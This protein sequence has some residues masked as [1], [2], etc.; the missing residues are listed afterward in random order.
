MW[1][2]T[3]AC[4]SLARQKVFFCQLGAAGQHLAWKLPGTTI[5]SGIVGRGAAHRQRAAAET[6]V[7]ESRS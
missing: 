4:R 6:R 3:K 1:C 5:G 2:E 7:T